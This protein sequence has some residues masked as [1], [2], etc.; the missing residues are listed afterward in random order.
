F[1]S[2]AVVRGCWE[3]DSK[4]EFSVSPDPIIERAQISSSSAVV[5]TGSVFEQFHFKEVHMDFQHSYLNL[6]QNI[7]SFNTPQV[8]IK[9]Q[10]AMFSEYGRTHRKYQDVLKSIA[11]YAEDQKLRC[12]SIMKSMIL[13]VLYYDKKTNK[14]MF[15]FDPDKLKSEKILLDIPKCPDGGVYSIVYKDGRRLFRCSLHGILRQN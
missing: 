13:A 4:P 14:K 5:A 10:K 9:A 3:T 12:F 11:S 15:K 2:L 6:I 7:N 8:D 1:I